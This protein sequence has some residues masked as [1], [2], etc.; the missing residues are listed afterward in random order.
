L[1]PHSRG[2]ASCFLLDSE[3]LRAAAVF[4]RVWYPAPVLVGRGSSNYYDLDAVHLASNGSKVAFSGARECRLMFGLCDPNVFF[5]YDSFGQPNIWAFS[6][7]VRLSPNGNWGVAANPQASGSTSRFVHDLVAD[8]FA[9]VASRV[10]SGE[11]K[12]ETHGI[13]NNGTAV[14]LTPELQVRTADGRTLPIEVERSPAPSRARIDAEGRVVVWLQGPVLH[15]VELASPGKRTSLLAED[16]VTFEMS[17][18]GRRIAFLATRSWP[19]LYVVNTDGTNRRQIQSVRD[20]ISAMTLSGDGRIAWVVAAG[21][22]VRVDLELD[23]ATEWLD[24]A[25][26]FDA[27]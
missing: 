12:W 17:D 7:M 10:L 13:A 21:R 9:R 16:F 19:Q 23:V 24:A 2:T 8:S 6:G 5:L 4:E 1:G 26:A 14:L 3:G 22:I 27:P 15:S 18:E 20:S 25:T 11:S